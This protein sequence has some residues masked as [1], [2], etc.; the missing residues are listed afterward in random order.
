[1]ELI[2]N[3]KGFSSVIGTTFMVLVMMFLGTSVFL[4][5]LS[6]NTIYNEAVRARNLEE[7]DRID[8]HIVALN[9]NYTVLG[10][11]VT[12][13]AVL[14]NTG[15]VAVQIINL[16][17]LDTDP[18]NRRYAN[19][20]LDLKL[21]PGNVLNLGDS[22]NATVTL[23]GADPNHVFVSWFVTAR[24]NT[25]PLEQMQ[26][27][28]QEDVIVAQV[29]Q[30]IGYLAM[31][32]DAFKVYEYASEYQLKDFP[33]GT[34]GYIVTAANQVVFGCKLTNYDPSGKNRSLTLSKDSLIWMYFPAQGKQVYWYIVNVDATGS[35]QPA[36]TETVL[37]Y[38]ETG[39]VYFA[40]KSCGIFSG[41]NDKQK[42]GT[43]GPA[44]INLLL[45]GKIGSED[46]GQNIPF[47][48]VYC[49]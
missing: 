13:K 9:G 5:T 41:T 37:G 23:P 15:S 14:K 2:A 7:A 11:Q 34:G 4:W 39:Y 43:V 48:S 29:A 8:E 47:V 31:D 17:V 42:A 32:F 33:N 25:V 49:S 19:K 16:W 22:S 12:V 24:G 10:D 35:V 6:Q 46:Y 1:M 20:S 18:T 27:I 30:G 28:E 21:N 3:S 44:A 45:I 26:E 36:Y 38:G 40:S